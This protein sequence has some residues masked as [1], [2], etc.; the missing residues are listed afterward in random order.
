MTGN[1]TG[2]GTAT[3]GAARPAAAPPQTRGP[4]EREASPRDMREGDAAAIAER[5]GSY[6]RTSSTEVPRF[7]RIGRADEAELPKP[8]KKVRV[9][10]H[11][12][13]LPVRLMG[14]VQELTCRLSAHVEVYRS[15]QQECPALISDAHI[16]QKIICSHLIIR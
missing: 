12:L 16:F 1:G 9:S 6:N 2:P 11:A 13:A 14:A 3:G 5:L 8:A 15:C 10:Q 7:T 4:P